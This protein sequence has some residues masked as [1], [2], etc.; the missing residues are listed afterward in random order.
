MADEPKKISDITNVVTTP[1]PSDRFLTETSAGTA[2]IS[3]ADLAIAIAVAHDQ[4]VD[5]LVVD[6][7]NLAAITAAHA[8]RIASLEGGV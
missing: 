5:Q 8:D 3:F 6:T 7:A 4:L 2:V 1:S